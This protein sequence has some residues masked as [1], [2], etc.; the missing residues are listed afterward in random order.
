[1]GEMT[2]SGEG[3]G[4]LG[5][6]LRALPDETLARMVAAGND[7]A[8]AAIYARYLPRLER[9]CRTLLRDAEESRD[10]AQDAMLSAYRALPGASRDM[11]LRPWLYRIA[12]NAAVDVLRRRRD[13]V[14]VDLVVDEIAVTAVEE[15]ADVRDRLRELVGD[16]RRLPTQQRGALVMR[17][18]DGLGYTDIGDVLGVS[19][20]AARRAVA[21]G[22]AAL[23]DFREARSASCDVVMSRI[24]SDGRTAHGRVIRA[25][26]TGCTDCRD[27]ARRLATRR[28]DLRVLFPLG[29][30]LALPV[31]LGAGAGGGAVATGGAL[32]LGTGLSAKLAAV[33]AVT[34]GV[35]VGVNALESERFAPPVPKAAAPAATP[36][37]A[38]AVPRSILATATP[39][40]SSSHERASVAPAQHRAKARTRRRA[41]AKQ[42]TAAKARRV[43]AV[44]RPRSAPRQPAV[45]AVRSARQITRSSLQTARKAAAATGNPTARKATDFG[46]QI[47]EK[48]SG[49]AL[50]LVE[51]ILGGRP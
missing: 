26:L 6:A 13:A 50:K 4:R 38:P 19:P 39:L 41:V 31:L 49:D 25:H 3:C 32:T 30:A 46:T 22:R 44:A 1:M 34:A 40:D 37:P 27:A 15:T 43:R 33:V 21:D 18:L 9:Y 28:R 10:V 17:E 29:P 51:S 2:Y 5:K 45:T 16:L 48:A 14:S 11:T 8:F 35:G 23:V 36:R 20:S 42:R 24:S 47:A 7:D 12:H